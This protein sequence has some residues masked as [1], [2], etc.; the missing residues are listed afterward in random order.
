MIKE[1]NIKGSRHYPLPPNQDKDSGM[2]RHRGPAALISKNN[3]RSSHLPCDPA[4]HANWRAASAPA[5]VFAPGQAA[6]DTQ[7]ARADVVRRP[8]A[9]R[10]VAY[11]RESRASNRNVKECWRKPAQIFLTC[12]VRSVYSAQRAM[13]PITR[14]HEVGS[15]IRVDLEPASALLAHRQTIEIQIIAAIRGGLS[16]RARNREGRFP[17]FRGVGL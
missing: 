10:R 16:G 13:H 14:R 15:K 17:A 1:S 11:K 8:R 9:E 5:L 6:T 3:N 7:R 2:K 4:Y 12:A